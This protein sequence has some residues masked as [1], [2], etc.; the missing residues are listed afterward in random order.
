MVT[1][2]SRTA[3]ESMSSCF[4]IDFCNVEEVEGDLDCESV[5]ELDLLAFLELFGDFDSRGDLDDLLGEL[6]YFLVELDQFGDLDFLC[7]DE[8]R[9]DVDLRG[10]LEPFG[11]FEWDDDLEV[12]G[13]TPLEL[14]NRCKDLSGSGDIDFGDLDLVEDLDLSEGKCFDSLEDEPGLDLFFG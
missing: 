8:Y 4:C 5:D 1:H 11:D 9:G 14:L 13:F 7:A 3:F 6:E 12:D 10:D 2:S